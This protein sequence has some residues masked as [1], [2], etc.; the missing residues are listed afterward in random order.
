M[1]TTTQNDVQTETT[2]TPTATT[3]SEW[4][5]IA[6]DTHFRP[7]P[8]MPQPERATWSRLEDEAAMGRLSQ[9]DWNLLQALRRKLQY[10]ARAEKH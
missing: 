7:I 5:W 10:R 3:V 2:E 4:I 9:D 1:T 8:A 6:P